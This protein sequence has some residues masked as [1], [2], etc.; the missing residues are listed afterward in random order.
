MR[1]RQRLVLLAAFAPGF[2]PMVM[3]AAAADF[4]GETGFGEVHGGEIAAKGVDEVEAWASCWATM[5]KA[6]FKMSF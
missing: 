1:R 2:A 6:F 3:V 4:Q 5:A